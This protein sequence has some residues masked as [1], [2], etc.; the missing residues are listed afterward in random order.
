MLDENGKLIGKSKIAAKSAISQVVL[1]RIGMCVPGMSMFNHMF[2]F[3]TFNLSTN[4]SVTSCRYG[5]ARKAWYT[6]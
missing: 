5:P 3:L 6:G 2:T 1:S 4:Y